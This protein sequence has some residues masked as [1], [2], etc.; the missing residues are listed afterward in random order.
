M[1]HPIGDHA[2]LADSRTAA[3]IDP[4]GNVAWLCWPWIDSTPLLFSI[5]DAGRGG[6]FSVRPARPDAR[7]VSRRYHPSS[8]VLETVWEVGGARLIVED[9]LDLGPGPLLIRGLRADGDAVDVL[10]QLA[11]PEWPGTPASLRVFGNA[12][13]L[14]GVSRVAVHAPSPWATSAGSATCEMTVRP[15]IAETV[16]LG[17]PD[18]EHTAASIESTLAEWRREIPDTTASI[19][20]GRPQTAHL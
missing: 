9:G 5:L 2:L 14:A 18:Q 8:L 17:A 16:T 15:G 11:A 7:A 6:G 20:I 12:V 19:D 1:Q 13:E 10:V 4:D 3:L